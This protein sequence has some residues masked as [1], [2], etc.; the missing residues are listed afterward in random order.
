MALKDKFTKDV[1]LG[2]DHARETAET[3]SVANDAVI[4]ILSDELNTALVVEADNN[5]TV[6]RTKLILQT[7]VE[8][9][10]NTLDTCI[11]TDIT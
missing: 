4:V 7:A 3:A 5:G 9:L 6:A 2:D 8:E 1:K 10:P 11:A